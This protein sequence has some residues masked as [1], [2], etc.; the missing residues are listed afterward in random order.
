V[1]PS[2]ADVADLRAQDSESRRLAQTRF[3]LPLLLEAGAGTG[4][5]AVLVG[6]I[7]AWSLGPGWARAQEKLGHDAVPERVACGVL[8]G[9]VAITFT[10]AAAAE[11][12]A[13]VASL[14]RELRRGEVPASFEAEALPTE[15]AE[16]ARRAEA[17]LGALDQLT[18]Q[19]IHAWCARLLR[20][21]PLE[22]G[23]HPRF[24][25]DADETQH[26]QIVREVVEQSLRASLAEEDDSELLELAAEGLGPDAIEEALG[27][28]VRAG[29]S[30]EALALDPL[31]PER[32][33]RFHRALRESL[34]HLRAC[35][36]PS[37][38]DCGA[39]RSEAVARAIEESLVALSGAPPVSQES[40]EPLLGSLREIW[41]DPKNLGRLGE[42]VKGP[43]SKVE[44]RALGGELESL[45]SRAARARALLEHATRLSPRL[46]DLV[47][48]VLLPLVAEATRCLRARGVETF[49]GLLRDVRTLLEENPS[50]SALVARE[51]D[52]LLVDEFQDTDVLQCQILRRLVVGAPPE[53]RPTLFVVGDPKQSIYG[54]R[55][56]D[57]GAYQSFADDLE[58]AGG[59]VHPLR[60]SF[61]AP[62][63]LLDE[64]ERILA[65]V[66][67][68]RPGVQPA[69]QGLLASPALSGDPG[70]QGEGFAPVEHWVSFGWNE[71]EAAPEPDS[72]ARA[73]AELEAEAVANDLVRLRQE[74][75]VAWQDVA[76]LFRS[77]G[78]L[79]VYLTA[80]RGAGIPYVVERDVSYYQRRE[81][82]EASALVRTV[83]DPHDHV[84]LLAWL[85][86]AAVGVP[87]A[88]LLPLW[89]EKLPVLAGTLHGDD[90]PLLATLR[91]RIDVIA[92]GL[93]ED[94]PG[95]ERI[96]GWEQNLITA[97]E[98]LAQVRAA[99]ERDPAD[100][101]VERLRAVFGVEAGEASRY[102]GV[103]RA[104]NLDRF[105]RTLVHALERSGGNVGAVL[106]DLRGAV[107]EAREE[108][109][110]RPR[111]ASG[112]AV[113]VLTIHKAKGLD[114][115]HV[116]LLQHHK[117]HGAANGPDTVLFERGGLLEYR[118]LLR[119]VTTPGFAEALL[120][121]RAV[122]SAE[123]VRTLYV[124]TTRA[125][126]RLVLV[127]AW[128]TS[129]A[130]ASTRSH[131]G[132]LS[133]RR[134]EPADL[135]ELMS[136]CRLRKVESVDAAEARFVFPALRARVPAS[137]DPQPGAPTVSKTALR[138][139][140]QALLAQRDG[141]QAR[142]ARP[143]STAASALRGE[144]D[145][146][147][148]L[149]RR[150]GTEREEAPSSSP[151]R[152]VARAVGTAVHRALEDL[153]PELETRPALAQALDAAGCVLSLLLG[154]DELDSGLARVREVLEGFVSG[155]LF[156]RLRE[157]GPHVLA[158]ELPVLLPPP[159]S[160]AGPVGFV[161]GAIDLVYRDP[162][163]NELVVVDYK[164]DRVETDEDHA[165]RAKG[166]AAQ[167]A[168]YRRALQEALGLA[169]LPRFELWFLHSGRCVDQSGAST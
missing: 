92:A 135:G 78:D 132:L 90:D 129:T 103:Y 144:Q 105:F 122:A 165:E 77:M 65:P 62:P 80:L 59:E 94:V 27:I 150:Y 10:E 23:L 100:V 15:T 95:I 93:P 54:W 38:I 67:H 152:A 3:D 5:T 97:L 25:V 55:N 84:A 121:S 128:P 123:L 72:N 118:L 79:D 166:Y 50:V 108:E 45:G 69:F 131:A 26:A 158:R 133:Q 24:E 9:V 21:F 169:E 134:P 46:L 99:F 61:R 39:G 73:R 28:L 34:E 161:S 146:E 126:R 155:A 141:A 139:R 6:R 124:A 68:S 56:A 11:M 44:N 86:S 102:L 151:E 125:R 57:L 42:W 163:T 143:F 101:F 49:D 140:S 71:A 116:Y 85:R 64:V 76:L 117:E 83:L 32:L 40:L 30:P 138:S 14:L 63:V 4:K 33:A 157:L 19:T 164:T 75:G 119:G 147:E 136:E 8:R 153:D 70:F 127:G 16:R 98:A 106:A 87:D 149:L 112:D 104:A 47:R 41:S 81:V 96:A 43:S 168:Q 20:R 7:V 35:G 142:E 37:L 17:V 159:V 91:E 113:Q 60:V 154:P 160:D 22:A 120:D 167:G 74:H 82:I 48:T 114:F 52:Q 88:A 31:S 145:L 58:A 12:A 137:L 2:H 89:Q 29:L 110:G 115:D 156:E 1:S 148:V 109:E 66:M 36:T 107:S 51:I 13:R 162:D 18:V 111:D 130:N 53:G